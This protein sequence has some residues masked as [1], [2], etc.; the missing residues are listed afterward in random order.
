MKQAT[1]K[2]K[3]KSD[4]LKYERLH[5]MENQLNPARFCRV[6]RSYIVNLKYIKKL[7]N[8]TRDSKVLFLSNGQKIPVSRSG[9]ERLMKVI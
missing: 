4:H 7:E 5:V 8:V 2:I 6:H 9:Y 1:D 3:L